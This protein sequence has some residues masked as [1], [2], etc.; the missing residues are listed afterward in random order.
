MKLKHVSAIGLFIFVALAFEFAHAD[1]SPTSYLA[2]IMDQY[3]QTFDVYT[4]NYSAGNHFAARGKMNSNGD[5]DFV[6]AM[7]ENWTKDP[8]S[9]CTCIKAT[10]KSNSNK[11]NPNWGGW[12]F[13]NGILQ[14][15]ETAPEENWGDYQDA[16]VDLTGAKTLTFWA[17]GAKGGEQVQFF[18][19][20]VGRDASTGKKT[21]PYPD[22]SSKVSL[23]VT[24]TTK[25]KKYTL[26]GLNKKDLSYVLGGFGWVASAS[27]NKMKNISFYIDD[28]RYDKPRLSEPRF[29]VSYKTICSS[30]DFDKVLR[31]VAY[32]YDN[33][34][35]LIAF[36]ASEELDRAKLMA[37]AFVYALGNDR[38]YTDGRIRNAYQGGDL[39]LPPG[40]TPH[41][42]VGTVRM[43]GWNETETGE[44]LE[45]EF[46]V[47]SHS[48]NVAW[49]MIA[50]LD[51]YQAAG[52][53]K[54]LN[55]AKKL[56]EWIETNCRDER[57]A[58]GYTG[59]MEGW[60]PD[61]TK[62]TYKSTEHNIDL[63]SAFLKLYNI[64]NDAG[65][66]DRA[67]HA[68]EF[69]LAM[70]DGEKFY[71]GTKDDGITTNTDP[72][73]LDCQAWS[74]LALKGIGKPY[75]PALKYAESHHKTGSGY[76]FNEDLDGIWFEGTG[77]MATAYSYVGSTS[78]WK[79]IV[80]FLKSKQNA[81]GGLW[82]ASRD[83]LTTGFNLADG[84][85]WLYYKRLHVG[86]T[87]WMEFALK[88]FNPF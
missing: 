26:S 16:G 13:M 48:G 33:A 7:N 20:G 80:K 63:Y 66:Q 41:G 19:F 74:V 75:W 71:T 64:T 21:N 2:T 68:K 51:Y 23:T 62:L 45:D 15:D 55:A 4:D 57:G 81:N 6:P 47:S 60:E 70:W 65:W 42:N 17:K 52:G 35:A 36:V 77:Q 87:G 38:Y 72:I 54:Y 85:P 69:V 59:G 31:N 37:D 88:K 1:V 5:S 44:W 12:Y 49:V 76:D 46:Q 79:T 50:L 82:A 67:N 3:H 29:L 8:H 9:G 34:V 86:A 73:P 25:W 28:I 30:S 32:A 84:D 43:P 11:K 39:V 61:Q 24:L 10:L 58:G 40:W 83:G 56:G 27:D 78:K 14:G 53:K 22:S 18:A